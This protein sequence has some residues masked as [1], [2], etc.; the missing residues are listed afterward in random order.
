MNRKITCLIVDDEPTAR[1][2]I[3]DHVKDTPFLELVASCADPFEA[4]EILQSTPVDLLFSDIQMPKVN[5][6]EMVRSLPSP[7]AIIFITAHG[8]FAVDS[9]ELNIADYL[10]K[11][12]TYERFLKAVNKAK[13]WI[14]LQNLKPASDI[15]PH[16][17]FIFVKADNKIIKILFKDIRYIEAA[18]NYVKIHLTN[19]TFVFTLYKMNAIEKILPSKKFFRIH[20]SYIVNI[21]VMK[22]IMGNSMEL[23]NGGGEIPIARD[24][25]EELLAFLNILQTK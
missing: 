17:E 5:G 10:L 19:N 23:I 8:E 20:N 24:R 16:Q 18:Q 7:P 12:V 14:E 22:A 9:Y 13:K 2:I 3:E 15:T 4:M 6:L 21:E 1:E 11:P 25:K